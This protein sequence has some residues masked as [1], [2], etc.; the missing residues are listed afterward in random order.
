MIEPEI[1]IRVH[2]RI[3]LLA[4]ETSLIYMVGSRPPRPPITPSFNTILPPQSILLQ[5]DFIRLCYHFSLASAS[6]MPMWISFLSISVAAT[7]NRHPSAVSTL[8]FNYCV[9][10]FRTY[11]TRLTRLRLYDFLV[12]TIVV[13]VYIN[14]TPI[15]AVFSSTVIPICCLVGIAWL[16]LFGLM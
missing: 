10:F 14:Q 7:A 3:N 15:S 4:T 6:L 9:V 16:A 12:I 1:N 11:V 5:T 2:C 8:M 13:F